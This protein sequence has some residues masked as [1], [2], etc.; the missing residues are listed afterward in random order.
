MST[1]FPTAAPATL[2]ISGTPRVPLGRLVKVEL[3][4]MMDTRSGFW[5]LTVTGILLV[6]AMVIMLLVGSLD[7]GARL[8]ANNF[9][10]T[11]L[12]IVSILVPVF[13]VLTVTSEWSQRTHLVTF[14]AEPD[15]L[16]VVL[17]KLLAASTLAVTTV[18]LAFAL[19]AVGNLLNGVL[20]GKE[21]V[22][23]LDG[24]VVAGTLVVQLLFFLMAFGLGLLLLN[25]PGAVS[26]FYLFGLLLPVMVYSSLYFVFGW[27]DD[28][29]PWFDLTTG[30]MPLASEQ[31]FTGKAFAGGTQQWAQL[32]SSVFLWVVLPLGI[33]LR[34]VL[35]SEVK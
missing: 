8:T 31:D 22:W 35:R 33:G 9:K 24:G 28:V 29:I 14:S 25:T 15:R 12:I 27:A 4:K 30:T 6:L 32:A 11:M 21:V 16:R 20:S 5:L 10:D 34:R 19:G 18:L 26:V 3:R 13:A 1:T 23:D 2:D 17:A 7:D